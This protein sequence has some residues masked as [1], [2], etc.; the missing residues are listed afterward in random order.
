MRDRLAGCIIATNVAP[1]KPRSDVEWSH[2]HKLLY[3]GVIEPWPFW[4]P[5]QNLFE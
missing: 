1:A 4:I 2:T 3:R 5:E